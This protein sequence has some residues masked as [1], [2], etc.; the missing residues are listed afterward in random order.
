MKKSSP[1]VVFDYT[2]FLGVSSQQKWTFTD[3]FHFLSSSEEI[4]EQN[5]TDLCE[6]EGRLWNKALNVLSSRKSDECNLLALI[7]IARSE[8]VKKLKLL[9]PYDLEPEQ[10]L[11]IHEHSKEIINDSEHDELMITL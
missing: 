8:G 10:L 9:M 2:S 3:A 1:S 4:N 11:L 7:E 6:L 5:Q